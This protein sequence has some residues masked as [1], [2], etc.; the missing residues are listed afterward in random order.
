MRSAAWSA[1]LGT[2]A[3]LA[4]AARAYGR[5]RR[6]A[7][8]AAGPPPRHVAII[9][10]GNRRFGARAF[11]PERRLEGHAAGAR[12]LGE[13]VDWC[14]GR[15]VAELTVFAF[16]TEN[17]DRDAGEV[18]ALMREFVARAAEV[19]R[20]CVERGIRCRILCTAPER[21]PRAA[22]AA[23][24][25]LEAPVPAPRLVLNIA[26]SYGARGEI[27]R[28]ARTLAARC[29]RG[30]L[31]A[32][33]IDEA[34]VERELLLRSPP[35]LVVRTSG[36]RRLSNF[37]LWQAAYAEL[38]FVEK[39]WPA[40]AECDLDAALDEYRRRGRRFGR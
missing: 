15:G 7:R 17:W 28:A 32:G 12:K 26:V 18:A 2:G 36:E 30:E 25:R 21:L 4:L 23:L 29:A 14:L 37:L 35:D 16:S 24:D 10:D 22:R 3:L 34:A 27:A 9:M 11:G 20:R 39:H 40:F 33:E 6:A 31:A 38:V 5:R 8:D 13:V 19:E 1:A